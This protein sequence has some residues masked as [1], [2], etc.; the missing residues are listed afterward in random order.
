MVSRLAFPQRRS[1]AA[2][3]EPSGK[4]RAAATAKRSGVVGV[5]VLSALSSVLCWHD[6][7]GE[8]LWRLMAFTR[9]Y[10]QIANYCAG[11]FDITGKNASAAASRNRPLWPIKQGFL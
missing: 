6:L 7:E 8:C 4:P 9:V 11:S 1:A 10:S 5:I 3:I 2:L